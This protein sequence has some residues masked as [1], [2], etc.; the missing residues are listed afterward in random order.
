MIK[1]IA[2]LKKKEGL[3]REEF[4][5]HYENSHAPLI[6]GYFQKF[7]VEYRRI[8][9]DHDHELS[10]CGNYVDRHFSGQRYDAVTINSFRN[11]ADL[12]EFYQAAAQPGVGEAIAA[13]EAKFLDNSANQVVV[14]L[15]ERVDR[16]GRA[17]D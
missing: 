4:I 6:N 8:Y 5:D 2:L 17:L 3:S 16:G 14:V 9:L 10:F 7:L 11:A 12:E 15:E 1:I 13:D